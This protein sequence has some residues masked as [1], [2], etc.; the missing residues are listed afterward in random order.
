MALPDLSLRRPVAT[1]MLYV[2]IAVVGVVSFLRLPIDLLPDVAFPTLSVWTTYSD[3]GPAEVERWVTEP[4]E[5]S[6]YS[7]PGA[8]GISSRSREGQSLVQLEFAWGTDMEFATLHTRENLDNL[9]ERLPDGAD[10][11]TILRSDPTSD[12]IMTLAVSGADLRN[13]RDISEVVFKRRLEQLD[14]VSLAGLTGGPERELRVI[15]D[16][17][18]LDVH[19]V[20]LAQISAALDQANYNAPGGTIRRG[21]FEYSL[22][23]LGQFREVDELLEVVI[24]RPQ[25]ATGRPVVLADV[26]TVVDTIADLETIARFN[27]ASAIGLQVFKEAGTNTV[28]VA[29]AVRE[30][31]DQLREEFPEISIEIASSQAA[32]IRDAISNVVTAL[33]FG[34]A[35]AFLVLFLFLRDPRYPLAIGLAIPISVMAAFALCYAFDVSLNIMSLG[36]LALGVGLLVDNSI[37]VL[38]NIFRHREESGEGA[39]KS[40]ARGAREVAAAITASTLT[41]IAVFGPVLYVEGVAGALFGDLSLA[42]TFSLLASLLVALTLLPVLAAQVARQRAGASEARYWGDLSVPERRPEAP[43]GVRAGLVRRCAH[44]VRNVTAASGRGVGRGIAYVVRSVRLT[45]AD[46]ATAAGRL[47]AWLFGPFLRAFERGFLRFAGRYERT[48]E[49]ALGN[50]LAIL[51]IAAAALAGAWAIAGQLP[52]EL[53]PRV[54]ERQFWVEIDLPQGTPIR[55]TDEAAGDIERLL[56]DMDVVS[57]VFTRVGRSRGSELAARD[58]TGLNNAALDVQLAGSERPT[59]DVIAELRRRLAESGFDPAF[60][61]IET[62]RATSLG[63]ALAIGEADLAVKVQG[64]ELEDLVP[65]AEAIETRIEG[66]G[67]LADVRLDFLRTQPELVIEVNREVAAR[68]QITVTSV[69]QAIEDYLRGSETTNAYS[70]FADK[71]DIRVTIPEAARRELANVLALRLEGVPIGE[72]VTV[73]QGFGPVEIRREDQNRT[74]QVLA[75]VAV[76]GLRAA[77]QEVEAEIA[78]IPR[79]ALTTVRVGGENE[80]MQNSFRSLTFAFGLALALVFLIMAAQ[81][82]SLV[83][84]LVV[85]T[86]VPLAGIGAVTALWIAGDGLNAMSGIGLVILIGIVV[87]DAIIK[88]DFINQRRRAGMPKR[89]AILEAGRLRLRPIVMTTITT[90]VGLLPLAAGLGAGADL[91]APLAVAVIGGLISATFLTLIVVPVVY[92]LMVEPSVSVEPEP[93]P[94]PRPGGRAP[95]ATEPGS[96]TPLGGRPGPAAP[97]MARGSVEP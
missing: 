25:R 6:L 71:I 23:T 93:Q 77:V 65:V 37:V 3:A 67:V 73:R 75:D 44:A 48:L 60:V 35:L 26:A 45:I 50:R 57:G 46:L 85:L 84:P 49:W 78:D 64:G 58:L 22:R 39:R 68:H 82:E 88:V 12:P 27:G 4:I 55:T 7:V 94:G 72:L 87:N 21:R 53:M 47:L 83:Q 81:F 56:L 36:G 63:R 92:S 59:P 9:S 15:V 29:D 11:P 61:S 54:D 91:R 66:V 1:A 97:G 40:A 18:Y 8:R 95:A 80:E 43:E 69:A 20:S 32:F 89:E 90:V 16:P 70:V 28:R 79:P 76:G 96:G 34:G 2:G 30:T 33:L 14:G 52:R 42:V 38:E 31:L 24:Q 10:R 19:E 74:I 13:L 5:Q 41:T 86:A 17:E 51:A 62:G